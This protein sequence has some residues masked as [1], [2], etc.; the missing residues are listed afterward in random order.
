MADS[1]C[2]G[3]AWCLGDGFLEEVIFEYESLEFGRKREHIPGREDSMCKGSV[4]QQG[5]HVPWMLGVGCDRRIVWGIKR[6][7]Q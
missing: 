5:T 3:V 2:G 6:R 1:A 7:I 4:A